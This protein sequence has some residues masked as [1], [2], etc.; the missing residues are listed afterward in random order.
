MVV[1][2]RYNNFLYQRYLPSTSCVLYLID[3]LYSLFNMVRFNPISNGVLHNL[4]IMTSIFFCGKQCPILNLDAR[5][6]IQQLSAQNAALLHWPPALSDSRFSRME[7]IS[8][9]IST[10]LSAARRQPANLARHFCPLACTFLQSL[11]KKAI[12]P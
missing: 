7:H 8:T 6:D 4:R 11:L 1:F 3:V 12:N 10:P 9:E 5:V 2:V